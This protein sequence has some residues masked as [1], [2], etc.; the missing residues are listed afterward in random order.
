MR[1]YA[2]HKDARATNKLFLKNLE[3]GQTGLSVAFDLPTQLGYDAGDPIAEGEVGKVGVPISTIEDMTELFHNIPLTSANTSMTI[4]ATAA[5]LLALYVA[6]AERQGVDLRLLRGTTQND[7]LKEYLSRGTRIFPPDPSL[8][9]TGDIIEYTLTHMPKWNPVNI[10]SY[11]LQ[12]AGATP[13]QEIA[14]TFYDACVILDHMEKRPG[15]SISDI[16]ERMAFFVNA[17]PRFIE[18]MSKMKAFI[19]L[20]HCLTLEEYGVTDP[21][22]RRFRYGVQVNSLGLTAVQPENNIVR[23]FQEMLAVTLSKEARALSVQLPAWNEALG[24]PRPWDQQWS[25]R[26]QQILAYESDILEYEE[27]IF[28]DA[29]IIEA[30]VGHLMEEAEQELERIR[31]ITNLPDALEYMK[32]ALVARQ[33]ERRRKIESGE[34]KVVGVNCFTTSEPSPLGDACE[35]RILQVNPDAERLQASR[36]RSF[37]T[38]R[39]NEEVRAALQNLRDAARNGNNLL[40]PSIRAAHVG[41]TTGEWAGVLRE[42]FGEYRPPTGIIVLERPNANTFSDLREQIRYFEEEHGRHPRF[43]IEKPGLDG[44]SNAAEQLA[45]WA[46]NAGIVVSYLGIRF[47]PEQIAQAAADEDVDIVGLSVLSGSHCTLVPRT[48]DAL[49]RYGVGD[50][51]V[52]GGTIPPEDHAF[53][54][55]HGVKAIYTAGQ[56]TLSEIIRDIVR[57]LTYPRR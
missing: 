54:F 4:N 46:S 2:G 12:E 44:H 19:R 13:V 51:P 27:D 57:L 23:I 30:R 56:A 6:V 10:C 39:N 34:I 15:I 7:I 8:R 43:L 17:G 29:T 52:V 16:V 25:L 55:S 38:R 47:T 35:R 31:Q 37:Y 20:W 49:R 50:I 41:V 45:V 42:A 33:S 9:L 28:T 26:L 22:R 24:L 36:I 18:E 48:I 32:T 3:K 1:T 21:A 40:P 53:L 11:H 14:F 5:W